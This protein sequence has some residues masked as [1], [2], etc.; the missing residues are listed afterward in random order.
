MSL[1]AGI[2][3][4]LVNEAGNYGLVFALASP[5]I[6]GAVTAAVETT[7]L[8]KDRLHLQ[9]ALDVAA[10]ATGKHLAE[11]TDEAVLEDYARYYFNANL[12]ERIDHSKVSVAFQMDNGGT[13]GRTIQL[14]AN[15]DYPRVMGLSLIHI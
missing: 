13:G 7:S 10:L 4:F 8:I 12:N 9:I 11:T 2:R 6:F 14:T 5:V 15:Y 3:R 1:I